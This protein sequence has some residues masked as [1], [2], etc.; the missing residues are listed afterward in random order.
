MK[1]RMHG[2][3]DRPIETDPDAPAIALLQGSTRLE[4][5]SGPPAINASFA[6]CRTLV[7]KVSPDVCLIVWPEGTCPI[8]WTQIHDR[9]VVD[10]I[11][12]LP[13]ERIRSILQKAEAAFA[14]PLVSLAQEARNPMLISTFVRDLKEDSGS[15]ELPPTNSALLID[16]NEG[17]QWRRDKSILA[18]FVESDPCRGL[19]GMD[20]FMQSEFRAG[21]TSDRSFFEIP[22]C[23]QRNPNSGERTVSQS[24][25]IAAVVTICFENMFSEFVRSQVEAVEKQVAGGRLLLNMSNNADSMRSQG[26]DMHSATHFFRAVENR[27]PVLASSNCGSS[28]WIGS[29]GRVVERGRAG[30]GMVLIAMPVVEKRFA[31]FR[32]VGNLWP[33]SCA[34]VVLAWGLGS[35][36]N[37][38]RHFR[39]Q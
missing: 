18:P 26:I 30:T 2:V 38:L 16:P 22:V 20:L 5:V 10:E 17:I 6:E 31:P 3:T 21:S 33:L 34:I 13:S 37:V 27:V 14:E 35:V 36:G 15:T 4:A 32:F 23:G 24:R 7:H 28:L 29:S 8:G 9:F 25:E 19:F 1:S 12:N 11:R 39:I